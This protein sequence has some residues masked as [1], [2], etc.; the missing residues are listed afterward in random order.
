MRSIAA[1]ALATS[2][3][4]SSAYAAPVSSLTAGKPAGVQQAQLQGSNTLFIVL[5]VGI[6]AAGI[7]LAASGDSNTIT[8]AKTTTTTTTTATTTTTT[9]TTA[10]ST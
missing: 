1:V 8:P 3:L 9:A 5:G 7:G 2:L 10:T 4:V 6:L